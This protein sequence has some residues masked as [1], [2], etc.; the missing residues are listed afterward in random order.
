VLPRQGGT[1]P[2]TARRRWILGEGGKCARRARAARDDRGATPRAPGAGLHGTRRRAL[3]RGPVIPPPTALG[4]VVWLR[5]AQPS[6]YP[7]H[8]TARKSLRNSEPASRPPPVRLPSAPGGTADPGAATPPGP[9]TPPEIR[10][11]SGGEQHAM[12]TRNG[13]VAF[14]LADRAV[15]PAAGPLAGQSTPQSLGATALRALWEAARHNHRSRA[16]HSDP[17]PA[18]DLRFQLD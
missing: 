2:K 1:T 18:R 4:T 3:R 11:T 10:D 6:A 14:L 13:Q 5:T 15:A 12:D 17:A 9:A 8:R 7:G 16:D